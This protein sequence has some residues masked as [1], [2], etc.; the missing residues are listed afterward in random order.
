MKKELDC[1]PV[2]NTKFLKSKIKNGDKATYF[3]GQ[4]IRKV[5]YKYIL[6]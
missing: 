4:E 6:V 1:K 2:Y 5:R 3:H